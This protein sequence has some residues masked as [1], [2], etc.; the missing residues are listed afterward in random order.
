MP[1]PGGPSDKYGNRFEGKWTVNCLAQVMA[2]EADFIRLEPPGSEGAGCEFT[3]HKGPTTE[4]H[5]V[6]RQHSPPGAW[7]IAELARNDVLRHAF[8]KTDRP[9]DLFIF[10]SSVSAGSLDELADAARRSASLGEFK[11]QFLKGNKVESWA[12]LLREWCTLIQKELTVPDGIAVEEQRA[13]QERVAY[14]HLRKVHVRTVDEETLS[15]TVD[16]RLRAMVRTLP[17]RVRNDLCALALENVHQELH[18]D[19]IWSHMLRLGHTRM[20]YSRDA[21]VLAAIEALNSRYAAMIKPIGGISIPR[22]ETDTAF[23]NL[24]GQGL[25]RSVLVSGEAGVGKTVILGQVIE[26]V[27]G[28]GMPHLYFRVDRLDP[29]EL[30]RNVGNQLDLPAS[31]VEVLAGVAKGRPC[32]LII[33]QLDAVSL[34]SGRNPEFFHCIHEIIRQA[35]AFPNMRLL[36]ACRRFDLEKDNRL[37]ELVTEHGPAIEVNAQPFTVE[38]VKQILERFGCS[39]SSFSDKQLELLRLP[40]HMS[41]FAQVA[42]QHPTETIM[43]VGALDLFDAFWEHKLHA[44][45]ERLGSHPD[46][47][48]PVLDRLC[49]SMTQR[50]T[51]FVPE[52][53]VL[54]E[55]E[56]TVR[57]MESEHVLVID[58]GRIG[59]FH[60]GFFDY[61]FARMFTRQGRDLIDYLKTGE[62]H[63]FK[64]AALRQILFRADAYDPAAF[65]SELRRVVTDPGIRFHLKK[66]ALEVA[67][68]INKATPSMW[69]LLESILRSGDPALSREVSSVFYSGAAW[70]SFLNA[71]G[72]L[73][74]WLES[75]ESTVRDRA[76]L[77]IRSRIKD[78]PAESVDLLAPYVGRSA[79]WNRAILPIIWHRVLSTDRRVFD[80]LLR[81]LAVDAIEEQG[82]LDLW[83]CIHDL[84]KTRPEWAAE[85]LGLYLRRMLTKVKLDEIERHF[86]PPDGA[87]QEVIPEIAANAPDAFLGNVLP[88]FLDVV[89]GTA[90][91]RDGNLHID[92]VWSSRMCREEP[93]Y[94]EDELLNGIETALR[95]TAE[96]SPAQ[97]GKYLDEL[98]PFGDYDSVNF[99][100]VRA[101]ATVSPEYADRAVEYLL[102][103]PQRLECG[104]SCGSGGDYEYWAA[105]ETVEHVSGLSS[106]A[107]FSRLEQ[108][109]LSHF[110]RWERSAP[111]HRQRGEWQ[112]IMLPALAANRRNTAVTA[113]IEE[114]KRKYPGWTITPPMQGGFQ[115]VGSP[116]PATAAE[117]MTDVQWLNAMGKYD[118][119]SCNRSKPHPL[120]QGGVHQLSGILEAE[121]KRDPE[122]FARLSAR[123]P[124]GA[125]P[126]Y[127]HAILRGLKDSNAI[128]ETAFAVVRRLFDIPGRLG[129]SNICDVIVKYS[130]EDIPNDILD[131]VGW[132]AT[133]SDDPTTDEATFH[134]VNG[135]EADRPLDMIS[136]AINTVRGQAAQAV[137]TLLFDRADR[138][139]LFLPY[140]E[141]MAC[142]PISVVRT[143]VAIALLGLY[144]YNEVRAVGLFLL[145]CETDQ[146][147]LLATHDV[148]RFIYYANIRH[149]QRL[150]PLLRRMLASHSSVVRQTGARL[151]CLAQFKNPEAA[152]MVAECLEGDDA[153]RM[154]AAQVATANVFYT[155]CR[156]F[157]HAA[158]ITLFDDPSKEIRDVVASCFRCAKGRDLDS[159]RDLIKAFVRS[160][161]FAENVNDLTWAM[162]HS[163]ADIGQEI[164]LV[165]EALV[166]ALGNR[167]DDP[168]Y[169]LSGQVETVSELVLRAYRQT[170]E[171]EYRV[172]CLD[173]IDRLL[174]VAA[175]G[176]AEELEAFER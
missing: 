139:P 46:Q 156:E 74:E 122:R 103:N 69:V 161:A 47:W 65:V 33:D 51:L 164:L 159:C 133:E 158:L 121:T 22:T 127:F 39:P 58:A 34:A 77:I 101:F 129:G 123:I 67:A 142:D 4:Y 35:D 150:R 141:K 25:K 19:A 104:W 48:L 93:L 171:E 31:P 92:S 109:I 28:E 90:R 118:A 73:S 116:I 163:T 84:P 29:T 87:G 155:H 113:R 9:N 45:K 68:K 86:L 60:E 114:W 20:D 30:P 167:G 174:S 44:V 41:I 88:V 95:I 154:G 149:F 76:L 38:N 42:K 99:L 50:Q 6:K 135:T 94:I 137:G 132:L 15:E 166:D 119:D 147:V 170:T 89:K 97:F 106:L 162:E 66:C 131:I 124:D 153:K 10:V 160:T 117:R 40:L 140:L 3:V 128:K 96:K 75:P 2:E 79:E 168:S 11:E 14:D 145:L 130:G 1:L 72:I 91:H 100:L 138:V 37:R 78:F 157:S 26:R 81:M 112:L 54:D 49:D 107:S 16:T 120:L 105:R 7:G 148:E 64:R 110:P 61:V 173:L 70:F 98:E 115:C 111:G 21:G 5:Q 36:L 82:H 151:A 23:A 83:S 59:F 169:R 136:T 146:D 27:K 12:Q 43:F 71:R 152:E 63:L 80:L 55:F 18:S 52:P 172:R 126:Y 134:R 13:A 165:C 62:Q 125:H 144:K 175:Y 102:A 143:K 176:I 17:E 32:V 57:A 108:T 85:A 56:R 8:E 24:S 53:S